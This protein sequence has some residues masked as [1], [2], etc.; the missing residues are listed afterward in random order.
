[1][2]K[3]LFIIYISRLIIFLTTL[4]F[5]HCAKD[6]S[7]DKTWTR[8]S[9]HFQ[10]KLRQLEKETSFNNSRLIWSTSEECARPCEDGAPPKN[11]YYHFQI[12]FYNSMNDNCNKCRPDNK[13]HLYNRP[14]CECIV[15]D[16][17]QRTILSL[18]RMLP[19]PSIQVCLN[20]RVVVDVENLADGIEASIHFHGLHQRGYQY[21]DGVPHLTQCPIA[22]GKTFR[23]YFEAKQ[24]GT[25]YYH[26]HVS[27]YTVDGQF[28][29]LVVRTPPSLDPHF[30]LYDED[31]PEHV[32]IICDWLHDLSI[33]R[34]IGYFYTNFEG[35]D[36]ILLNGKGRYVNYYD[37]KVFSS[38]LEKYEVQRGKRYRFRIIS[39]VVISCLIKISVVQHPLT[40]IAIDGND[41][42]PVTVDQ[43]VLNSGD[44]VDVILTAD[45][46]I[47]TYIMKIESPGDCQADGES[48]ANFPVA[49]IKYKVEP[50][51][52]P[53]PLIK[54]R[55]KER[56]LE[57]R[58]SIFN[59]INMSFC[60]DNRSHMICYQN[61]IP[62]AKIDDRLLQVVP[63]YRFILPFSFFIF[64]R[65]NDVM[66][67][68]DSYTPHFLIVTGRSVTSMMDGITHKDA[69]VPPLSQRNQ[70]LGISCNSAN[71]PKDCEPP[72]NC[73][74]KYDV[75]KDSIV[76]IIAYDESPWRMVLH[77]FH[78]H[79]HS[80][81][82]F[83]I[84][85]FPGVDK[86]SKEHLS[87]VIA[88]HEQKLRNKEY[89]NPP[90]KDSLNAPLRGYF[91]IRFIADNPG[92]WL[93]HCHLVWHHGTGMAMVFHVGEDSDLPPV[94]PNFPECSN[95]TPTPVFHNNTG[96]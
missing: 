66:F 15:A 74:H 56:S 91:I 17:I 69:A 52:L 30:H 3:S 61:L 77:A 46:P 4:R 49:I 9:E 5:I 63:D 19:G 27:L 76:E 58:M 48:I 70:D 6:Y 57:N 7:L 12:E 92:W 55:R 79:G 87:P 14:R 47:A 20:D 24:Q 68:T 2:M 41:I 96:K 39:A 67:Q 80:F 81:H 10:R 43:V 22:T 51:V 54:E 84:G 64:D 75:K 78:L 18:N 62:I 32:L 40:V 33:F 88:K 42:E 28:G 60:D 53:F 26:S 72:C 89:V 90:A 11:C 94:P 83:D 85:Q 44:R 1:M 38:E 36:S 34:H 71:M 86:L 59:P 23:Y 31:L 25:H 82:I 45:K 50:E 73:F 21:F 16:G 13:Q 37:G 93:F 95:F 35:T 65:T 29:S 8:S